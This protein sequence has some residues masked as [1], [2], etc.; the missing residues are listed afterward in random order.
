MNISD[1]DHG[2]AV[3]LCKHAACDHHVLALLCP[4]IHHEFER[5][6]TYLKSVKVALYYGGEPITSH[7]DALKKEVPSIVVG[8]PGRIKQVRALTARAT[9]SQDF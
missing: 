2:S 5:F 4:Q 7:K 1:V 3:A 9:I 8:T 6:K